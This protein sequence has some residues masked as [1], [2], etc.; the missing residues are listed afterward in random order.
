M[1]FDP[2]EIPRWAFSHAMCHGRLEINDKFKT[3][4]KFILHF[5][6]LQ[7]MSWGPKCTKK[8]IRQLKVPQIHPV[9]KN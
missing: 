5:Y 8:V 4:T 2:S 9:K 1:S 7:V 3:V 6:T